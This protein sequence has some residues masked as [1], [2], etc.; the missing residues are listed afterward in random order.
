MT[1]PRTSSIFLEQVDH[2]TARAEV[3]ALSPTTDAPIRPEG[4]DVFALIEWG[5]EVAGVWTADISRSLVERFGP[6]AV[7]WNYSLQGEGGP[8]SSWCRPRDSVITPERNLDRIAACLC[9]RRAW[10]EELTELFE[11]HP[12]E[13]NDRKYVWERTVVLIASRVVE[14]TDAVEAWHLHCSS[15]LSWHLSQCGVPMDV[16][17][18]WMEE[19]IEEHFESWTVPESSAVQKV[20]RQMTAFEWDEAER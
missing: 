2:G 4:A 1:Y 17:E 14:R 7:G 11:H 12:L 8:V 13:G 3:A 19:V 16:V 20:A 18:E 9:E 15:A 6:W 5:R 10:L